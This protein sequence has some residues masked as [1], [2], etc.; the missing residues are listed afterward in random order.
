M[1][2]NKIQ[3]YMNVSP[4]LNT[5]RTARPAADSVSATAAASETRA[6]KV[7]LS[8]QAGFKAQLGA[9][10]K[11]YAAEA[12]KPASPERINQLKQQYQ[13]DACPVS[14]TDIASAVLKYTLGGALNVD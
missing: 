6:D 2:I 13:G 14:G 3:R 10:A 9:Y 4:A 8:S 7:D 11:I 5:G 12:S 1:D